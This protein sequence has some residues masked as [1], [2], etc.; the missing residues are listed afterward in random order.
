MSFVITG[1]LLKK[2]LY[3]IAINFQPHSFAISSRT[4]IDAI[5]C[6]SLTRE[7]KNTLEMR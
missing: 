7:G 5:L 1:S 4:D 6:F 2:N 3:S